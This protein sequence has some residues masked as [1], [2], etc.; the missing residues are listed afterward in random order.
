MA[1]NAEERSAFADQR[2]LVRRIQVDL[3]KEAKHL[4]AEGHSATAGR[5]ERQ[6]EGLEGVLLSLAALED[7]IG[8]VKVLAKLAGRNE[9]G[10]N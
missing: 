2:M 3:L 7:V 1:G 9:T 6:A 4:K 5:L 8:A 10:G